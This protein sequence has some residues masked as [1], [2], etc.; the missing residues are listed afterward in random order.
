MP[1]GK[2]RDLL[3]HQGQRP[4]GQGGLGG[5]G[6][7][8]LLPDPDSPEGAACPSSKRLC[9]SCIRPASHRPC[10]V[11]LRFHWMHKDWIVSGQRPTTDEDS[12]LLVLRLMILCASFV[13]LRQLSQEDPL[14]KGMAAHSSILG[15]KTPWTGDPDRLCTDHGVA[16]S[17]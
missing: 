10:Q 1:G 5:Q 14:E 11:T 4:G 7:K 16:E 8:G 15:W 6:V 12:V 9:L 2:G 17:D 3:T 13:L